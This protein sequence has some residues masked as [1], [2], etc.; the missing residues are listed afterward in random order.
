MHTA[1]FWILT[2]FI[3]SASYEDIYYTKGVS[4]GLIVEQ[5]KILGLGEAWE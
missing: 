3:V 5:I 1:M 2:Q 4:N